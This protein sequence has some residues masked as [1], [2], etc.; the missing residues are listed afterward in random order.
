MAAL[1]RDAGAVQKKTKVQERRSADKIVVLFTN[2][3]H[4]SIQEDEQSFGMAGLAQ[5]KDWAQHMSRYVTLVDCGDAIQGEA[6]GLLSDGSCMVDLMNVI[7]YDICTFGN[8]EFD[9]G[10]ERILE[11]SKQ[12]SKAVYV[13]C[14]FVEKQTGTAVAKPYE[15]IDYDGISVAYVGVSTPQT[16][17][18]SQPSAFRDADGTYLYGFC[19]GEDGARF[20]AAV[21][22]AVDRARQEGADYVIAIAHLG[23]DESAKPYRSTDLIGNTAGIDAVL[24]GHSHSVIEGDWIKNKEGKQ[25]L[26]SSAGSR[27]SKIGCLFIDTNGTAALF[28]DAV[29]TV[30]LSKEAGQKMEQE[31]SQALSAYEASLKKV[32]AHSKTALPVNSQNG[33]RMVRNQETAIGNF[34]ADACRMASGADIA[35]VNG[36]GIRAG[37]PAGEITYGDFLDV[38]PYGNM[39]SVV[40]A[41]G[42]ELLDMLEMAYKDV[43]AQTKNASG[44]AGEFGGFLHISGL[45]VVI[46]QT[47]PSSVEIDENGMFVSVSGRRRVKK[48][49]IF[50][51]ET[52]TYQA[53][54]AKETYTLAASDYMLR[55][56][57]DGFSMFMDN[58][59]V[60]D[61]W[62]QDV[63]ALADYAEKDLDGIIGEAYSGVQGRILVK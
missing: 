5:A 63:Q 25:V 2:D 16:L 49:E 19:Q 32:V 31:V 61:G 28:D 9:F 23:I 59:F 15:I 55:E 10:M 62:I 38:F 56:G 52:G 60:K 53:L 18:S 51:R 12:R 3:M 14:N 8:H 26:L 48:A 17:T 37:L 6:A 7:G 50:R 39:L 34:C 27:L 30:L 36:G 35:V 47:I 43:Q 44:A 40:K 22:S 29:E 58:T 54:D 57:G 13:S 1:C 21:Q 4:C 20:Y 45:R 11:L 46:D 42:Q 41:S 24:D 33:N